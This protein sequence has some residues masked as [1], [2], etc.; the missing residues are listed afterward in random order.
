MATLKLSLSEKKTLF[1]PGP[2]GSLEAV[3]E[4]GEGVTT[5]QLILVMCHPNPLE[6]GTMHNKVVTTCCRAFHQL[7]IPSLRFN[8]RG[9]GQSTG[10]S[11]ADH[12]EIEDLMAVLSYLETH[13][14]DHRWILGGFSFGAWVAYEVAQ[15]VKCEHL[16]TIAPAI[17]RHVFSINND[18]QTPWLN[19]IGDQ[20]EIVALDHFMNWLSS[21]PASY[22][23]IKCRGVGHFFHGQLV[24][25]RRMIGQYFQAFS[26]LRD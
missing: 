10:Q 9:V 21:H 14:V 6:E 5:S 24:A 11:R 22:H 3:I 13:L 8:F 1:I 26:V 18:W 23:L 12:H 16:L 25:L 2:A 4:P 20:D 7:G 17:G 19:I 15:K